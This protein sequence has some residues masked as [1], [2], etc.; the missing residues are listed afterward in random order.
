MKIIV[1]NY[2]ALYWANLYEWFMFCAKKIVTCNPILNVNVMYVFA[3]NNKISDQEALAKKWC[4]LYLSLS[5]QRESLPKNENVLIIYSFYSKPFSSFCCISLLD[6][7]LSNI[8]TFIH[9]LCTGVGPEVLLC[10]KKKGKRTAK[11]RR[12]LYNRAI[13]FGRQ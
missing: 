6:S 9:I 7:L 5:F 2:C 8:V 10:L 12:L 4:S 11:T 1:I 3:I 13:S